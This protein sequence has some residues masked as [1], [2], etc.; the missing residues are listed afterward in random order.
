MQKS[1]NRKREGNGELCHRQAAPKDGTRAFENTRPPSSITAPILV[2]EALLKTRPRDGTTG[3]FFFSSC[4]SRFKV[5]TN[6]TSD[7]ISA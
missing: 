1:V 5:R 3:Y 2:S 4:S 7:S 6:A